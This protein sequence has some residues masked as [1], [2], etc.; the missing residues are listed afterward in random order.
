M[1]QSSGQKRDHFNCFLFR[2]LTCEPIPVEL[3]F[4]L[5]TVF[6]LP[7]F[8]MRTWRVS[9]LNGLSS[10]CLLYLF[11]LQD[12]DI[13][14]MSV[15]LYEIFLVLILCSKINNFKGNNSVGL[16]THNLLKRNL[17]VS[18]PTKFKPMLFKDQLYSPVWPH[19]LHTEHFCLLRKFP[20]PS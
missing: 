8:Q 12:Y 3:V 11:I 19:Q 7:I 13:S 1:F 20:L 14:H 18:Q 15:I 5:S 4:C 17:H 2:W 10:P 9:A 6:I 16:Y